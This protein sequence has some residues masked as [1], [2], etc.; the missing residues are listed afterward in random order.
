MQS[1]NFCTDRFTILHQLN[2]SPNKKGF[3]L[4]G[5]ELV[6][7][8]YCWCVPRDLSSYLSFW[9]GKWGQ[10]M[11]KTRAHTSQQCIQECKIH[12]L[13][14]IHW[15]MVSG[16]FSSSRASFS[17]TLPFNCP[18]PFLRRKL[19]VVAKSQEILFCRICP[20]Q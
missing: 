9:W 8:I 20:C 10:K 19:P 18:P 7:F 6:I 17:A 3:R 16:L 12:Q 4:S 13:F 15:L 1:R 5:F 11:L 2:N 14:S